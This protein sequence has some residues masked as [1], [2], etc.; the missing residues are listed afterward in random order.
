MKI[1]ISAK[2]GAKKAYIKED[3]GGLFNKADQRHFTVAVT[4]RAV[5]GAA[6][7][8]IEEALAAYFK[9][10]PSHVRIVAGQTARKKIA[11]ITE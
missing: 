3:D 4:A 10:A 11:E 9:V 1:M 6:N 5:Q 7:R 2:P 8:A